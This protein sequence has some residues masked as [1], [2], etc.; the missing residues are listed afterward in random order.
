MVEVDSNNF[1]P[2]F[3]GQSGSQQEPDETAYSRVG[4]LI[5]VETGSVARHVLHNLKLHTQ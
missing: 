2:Q 3:Q 1:L 4:L 5:V